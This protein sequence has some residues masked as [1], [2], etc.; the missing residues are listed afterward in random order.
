MPALI[1]I[2]V[3]LISCVKKVDKIKNSEILTLPTIT[4]KNTR[5]VLN[6]S[7]KVQLIMSFPLM[8]TYNNTDAPYSEWRMGIE[9]LFY[10]GKKD[11]VGRVTAKYARYIDKKK[12]WE[13]KDSV[14]VVNFESDYKLETEQLFWDQQKDIIYND[15]FVKFSNEDQSVFGNGFESDSRLNKRKIKNVSGPIY[16]R[17]E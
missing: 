11:S 2:A 4:V 13:L 9:V 7:G 5:S 10:D 6:D 14:V 15:R 1:I 17:D 16:L 8:E 12:L 3:V